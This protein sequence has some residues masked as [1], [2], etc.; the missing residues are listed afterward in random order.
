MPADEGLPGSLHRGRIERVP[1]PER[2]TLAERTARPVP[3]GVA[4]LPIPCRA[5]GLEL[6]RRLSEVA[7]DDI[8]GQ[9]AVQGRLE[10]RS[11]QPSRVGEANHLPGGMDTGIRSA[12]RVHRPT[13]PIAEARQRGFELPLDRPDPWL[14]HLEAG[15][16]RPVIFDGGAEAPRGGLSSTCLVADPATVDADGR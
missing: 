9:E 1:D 13:N 11:V 5:T 4:V 6:G 3:D 15:K 7:D 12:G 16:I 10:R 8:R 14:L 2:I